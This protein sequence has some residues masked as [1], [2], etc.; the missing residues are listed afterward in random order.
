MKE[1]V[2]QDKLQELMRAKGLYVRS[3]VGNMFSPGLP[4]MLVIGR[5]GFIWHI[6]NKVWR[7]RFA[8]TCRDDFVQLLEGPQR[9]VIQNE[10]WGRGAFCPMI[11][12]REVDI[13]RCYWYNNRTDTVG[14]T[15]WKELVDYFV[16]I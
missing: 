8:P 15:A 2:F 14:E 4:D 16:T 5:T 9:N 1:H 12:F 3:L 11:A 13:S 7:K 6:E 10:F